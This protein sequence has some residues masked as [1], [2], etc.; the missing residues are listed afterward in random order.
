[1]NDPWNHNL[2]TKNLIL[3][4]LTIAFGFASMITLA[5]I[6]ILSDIS[7]A[8][9]TIGK[10]TFTES[11]ENTERLIEASPMGIYIKPRILTGISPYSGKILGLD[12][13][14]NMI[15]AKSEDIV[16]KEI[17]ADN[18]GNHMATKNL[19]IGYH[20][21]SYD[22]NINKGIAIDTE[23]NLIAYQSIETD[24]TVQIANEG[25]TDCSVT[26]GGEI[27]YIS[28]CLQGCDSISRVDLAGSGC[29]TMP[30]LSKCQGTI[31]THGHSTSIGVIPP[32][33]SRHHNAIAEACSF[34]CNAPGYV[35]NSNTNVCIPATIEWAC[36]WL[37]EHAMWNTV[38]GIAIT[39][40]GTSYIPSL[41][42]TYNETW[43]MTECRFTCNRGYEWNP[44]IQQCIQ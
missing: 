23:N 30:T 3:L 7:N 32:H 29:G 9:Q 17:M 1:M 34:E 31:D 28:W 42:W 8:R 38:D 22:G 11:G 25:R 16:I 41:T 44:T 37:P 36:Q 26:N 18:M 24:K 20:L 21:I 13:D 43:S 10:V 39:W 12:K 5:Q 19:A 14:G 4:F 35:W 2:S 33:T 15:Y 40:N 27:R 6:D